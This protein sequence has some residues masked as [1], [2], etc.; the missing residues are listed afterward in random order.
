MRRKY[1]SA[2]YWTSPADESVL[3]TA[4]QEVAR[5]FDK[6]LVTKVLSLAQFEPSASYYQRYQEKRPQAPFC[7]T[8]IDPKLALLQSRYADYLKESR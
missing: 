4:L 8:Y 6:P 2:I 3:R 5:D 7:R 1:R